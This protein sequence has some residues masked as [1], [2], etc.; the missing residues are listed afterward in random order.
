MPIIG[1]VGRSGLNETNKSVVYSY[2]SII[3]IINKLGGVSIT[4]NKSKDFK[5]IIDLCDGIIMQGG[6]DIEEYDLDIIKYCYLKDIPLLSI[7]L[8]MQEMGLC[9]DG[10]LKEIKNHNNTFH[11]VKIDKNSNLYKY[12]NSDLIHVNSRHKY[13]L[14]KTN[15]SVV[16]MCD[17][18][19][20]A[21]EDKTKRFFVGVQWHPEDIFS[22]NY[23]SKRLFTSFM[24]TIKG[25]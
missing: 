4:I 8:G 16:G 9:F 19:I 2:E 10:N 12:I 20:E 18:V 3:D 15:L 5:K 14:V 17:Q 25:V 24:N 11:Y 22:Y 21:I 7:C 6:N 13:A 23:S 1:I